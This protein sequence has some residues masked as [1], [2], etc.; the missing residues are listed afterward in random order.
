MIFSRANMANRDGGSAPED[1]IV[2]P[3][4]SR[5]TLQCA[6]SKLALKDKGCLV[7]TSRRLDGKS[8]HSMM[9]LDIA[10][11]LALRARAPSYKNNL[12]KWQMYTL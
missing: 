7:P 12:K 5:K 9:H 2:I 11:G 1:D 6:N 4:Q 3:G 10:I 8:L